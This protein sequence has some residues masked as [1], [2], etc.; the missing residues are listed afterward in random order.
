MHRAR[1]TGKDRAGAEREGKVRDKGRGRSQPMTAQAPDQQRRG[2]EVW[3]G[4]ASQCVR[5]TDLRFPTSK[6]PSLPSPAPP[7]LCSYKSCPSPQSLSILISPS[8]SC[9]FILLISLIK[10]SSYF[11]SIFIC[12]LKNSRHLFVKISH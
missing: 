9:V 3:V 5:C 11:L 8:L 2:S 12:L 6:P 4:R 10:L 1:E 7:S